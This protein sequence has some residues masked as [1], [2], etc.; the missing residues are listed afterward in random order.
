MIGP[1]I[2]NAHAKVNL[3]ESKCAFQFVSPASVA[4]VNVPSTI[5]NPQLRNDRFTDGCSGTL[6]SS[7]NLGAIAQMIRDATRKPNLE[8]TK[9]NR[10]P[11]IYSRF[12][13]T[14]EATI[15]AIEHDVK[16]R[17]LYLIQH[18]GNKVKSL[19]ENCLLLEPT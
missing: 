18:C 2:S 6:N 10:N 17:L 3:R 4:L 5:N 13:S 16:R 12:M 9:F 1:A 8:I 15:E 19:I 14:F 11:M 7:S